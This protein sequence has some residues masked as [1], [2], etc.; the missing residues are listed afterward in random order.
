M[1]KIEGFAPSEDNSESYDDMFRRLSG[2]HHVRAPVLKRGD[3][4]EVGDESLMALFRE[5]VGKDVPQDD[6]YVFETE[7][8]NQSMDSYGTRMAEMS[9]S[10]YAQD[11]VAG[12][13]LMNSHKTGYR[14]WFTSEP[15]ELP[16]GYSFD[17]QLEGKAID[18]TPLL[19]RKN[20]K[21]ADYDPFDAGLTLA[22]WDYVRRG[23][24]PNGDAQIGTDALILGIESRSI[25][26]ISIGFGA[27]REN[28]RI[29]YVCG[30][31]GLPLGGRKEIEPDVW[32]ECNHIPLIR[33]KDSEFIA[34]AWVRDAKM[35]EHSTVWAGANPG[36]GIRQAPG[37]VVRQARRMAYELTGE[38]KDYLEDLWRVPLLSGPQ[39]FDMGGNTMTK[40]KEMGNEGQGDMTP[41]PEPRA[42]PETPAE[43]VVEVDV[44][45]VQELVD[46]LQ[47]NIG[48]VETLLDR[49]GKRIDEVE[50]RLSHEEEQQE[51][52]QA[53][54]LK[55]LIDNLVVARVRAL[56]QGFDEKAYRAQV[57]RWTPEQITA[58][59]VVYEDAARKLFKEGRPTAG[60]E[61]LENSVQGED[62]DPDQYRGM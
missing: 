31:C 14:G 18:E 34:F 2:I 36:A 55:S 30:L 53:A 40:E 48:R 61:E 26:D 29:A 11:A 56:G 13:P 45:G 8:S 60:A 16:L 54:A 52:D 7:P 9:I 46:D 51:A 12:T 41:A 33:D 39:T 17:G 49:F 21:A 50:A 43:T 3:L 37:A 57:A 20:L 35:Y 1:A 23:Y 5:R 15:A 44:S 10:Q 28:R 42:E 22:A 27:L 4:A 47:E 59:T 6:I 62:F 25:R 24:K 19:D 58:E 38:E 32:V